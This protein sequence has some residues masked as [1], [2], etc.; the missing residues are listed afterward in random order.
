MFVLHHKMRKYINLEYSLYFFILLICLIFFIRTGPIYYPDSDGYL[1]MW[2]IRSCGYPLFIAFFKLVF[3]AG[4]I[5]FLL[6]AQ[7]LLS[8]AGCCYLTRCIRKTISL[9]K[10]LTLIVFGFLT[11]PVVYEIKVSNSILSESLAYP[12]YLFI[13][14]NLL[15]AFVGNQLKNYYSLFFLSYLLILIRGQFLFIIPVL[16]IGILILTLKKGFTKEASLLI[17]FAFLI[18]ITAM[19]TDVIFHK[20]AHNKAIATPWTGIQMAALPFFV[21]DKNDAALFDSKIEQDYFNHIYKKLQDKKIALNQLYPDQDPMEF[22][23]SNYTVICNKTL[24]D[25]G[26]DFFN[27]NWSID[28]KIIQNEKITAAIAI[29]LLKDNFKEWFGIYIQNARKGLGSAKMMLLYTT[30][31]VL[32]IFVFLKKE[33]K[34]A[35][36]ILMGLLLLFGNVFLVA[37]VEPVLSRY[38]F[39]NN[40]I[41]ITIILFLFQNTF[42]KNTDE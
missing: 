16:I 25:D 6:L 4:Y 24:N 23:F 15:L 12:L 30:L 39:Y 36:F 1:N 33:K 17:F 20:I 13:V 8:I 2:L 27:A 10:W 28:E 14:G 35:L 29:P 26:L 34:H 3:G 32:S 7:F 42:L 21:A 11:V 37:L 38:T 9:N 19:A 40:W 22:Y 18:P 41:L 31:L 5:S